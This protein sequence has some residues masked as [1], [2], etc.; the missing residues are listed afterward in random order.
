M[1]VKL[2]LFFIELQ[3]KLIVYLF[4]SEV[5]RSLF[6]LNTNTQEN[7]MVYFIYYIYIHTHTHKNI[8]VYTRTH[9]HTYD[10]ISNFK[11]YE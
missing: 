10:R 8:Y 11:V 4:L 2:R 1:N 6:V 9:T 3:R 7:Y 5:A